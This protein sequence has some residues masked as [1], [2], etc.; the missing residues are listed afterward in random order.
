MDDKILEP[1]IVE[2]KREQQAAVVSGAAVEL[3]RATPSSQVVSPDKA[4]PKPKPLPSSAKKRTVSI[5]AVLSGQPIEEKKEEAQ[6]EVREELFEP[7]TYEQL[8]E[9]WKGFAKNNTDNPQIK[10]MLNQK[11]LLKEGNLV[12]LEI[13][14]SVQ[15]SNLWEIK[16]KLIGFLHRELKNS[17]IDVKGV[18]VENTHKR[19]TLTDEEKMAEMAKKNPDFKTFV[20]KFDLDCL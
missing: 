15:Q 7:F 6:K 19:T 8:L 13:E 16:P 17:T 2:E 5:N 14:N 1:F 12:V 20:K 10:T 4:T 3:Q 18:I 9:K 11:P